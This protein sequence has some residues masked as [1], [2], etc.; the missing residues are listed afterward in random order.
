M[1]EWIQ[2]RKST[3]LFVIVTGIIGS[4]LWY[5]LNQAE[6]KTALLPGKTTHGHHQIE[7]ECAACHTNE[8]VDNIFTT[9]GVPN[10]ACNQCHGE[11]LNLFSDSHR[12]RKFKN[13]ENAIYLKHIDALNCVACHGEHNEKITGTMG[14]TLPADYCAH[15]HSVTLETVRL[16]Q[17]PR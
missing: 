9:S 15:C 17:L 11:A 5:V 6:N 10:S 7:M 13:P 8:K 14:V 3:I 16:P 2:R 12:V 1:L 4:Y